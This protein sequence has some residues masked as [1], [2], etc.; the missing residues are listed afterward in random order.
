MDHRT[1]KMDPTRR[2]VVCDKQKLTGFIQD[3]ELVVVAA[4]NVVLHNKTAVNI[5]PLHGARQAVTGPSNDWSFYVQTVGGTCSR[6]H[7][8]WAVRMQKTGSSP[9]RSA[10]MSK[11]SVTCVER[12][13]SVHAGSSPLPTVCRMTAGQGSKFTLCYVP[14]GKYKFSVFC[15]MWQIKGHTDWAL[16]ES[17]V[18]WIPERGLLALLMLQILEACYSVYQ[19][20]PLLHVLACRRSLPSGHYSRKW[21]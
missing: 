10:S 5:P 9:G 14:R 4:C 12:P 19:L 15:I 13:S 18:R 8:L 2:T 21:L 16:R 6:R 20:F 1:V 3:Y 7:V 17:K 11:T